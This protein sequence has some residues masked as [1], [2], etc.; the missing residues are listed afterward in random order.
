MTRLV[1]AAEQPAE[2]V[3]HFGFQ[4]ESLDNPEDIAANIRECCSFS[5][6]DTPALDVTE[7]NIQA[8]V[9]QWTQ[10]ARY[11]KPG[12]HEAFVLI[13]DRCNLCGEPKHCAPACVA[14]YA[15][16]D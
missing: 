4:F 15:Y 7:E 6:A 14:T 9:N 13:L 11:G 2:F 5:D 12:L 3:P 1:Y 10:D 16:Q 8:V